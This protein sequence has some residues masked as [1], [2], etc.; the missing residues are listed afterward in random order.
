MNILLVEDEN[1]MAAFIKEALTEQHY[2]VDIATDGNKALLQADI[3]P[4]DLFIL[5]IMIPY[6]DGLTVCKELRNN[7][8]ESPIL[9]LT[10]K[11]KLQD[12]VRG[13]D[14]GADDYLS[15]PF[16]IEELLARVRALLRRHKKNKSSVL[17]V[18][19]LTLDQTTQKVTRSG[20][21]IELTSKE[22]ALLRYLMIHANEV[23]SRTMI[24]EHVWD[25]ESAAFTNVVD[26]YINYI[27]TKVDKDFNPPLIH[28]VRSVG[29]ILK[30]PNAK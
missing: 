5:D 26:V 3:N 10:A 30:E 4:Y 20:K 23:V 24:I 8:I 2:T 27:R 14:L 6:K 13:L 22:Y 1:K 25:V 17:K 18:A 12:K 11:S 21:L 7:K 19:D 16:E 29:Y 15:K 9:L 28:A